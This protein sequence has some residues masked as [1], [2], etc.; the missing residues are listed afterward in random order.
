MPKNIQIIWEPSLMQKAFF[1][2]L[3]ILIEFMEEGTVSLQV[4][5]SNVCSKFPDSI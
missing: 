2:W 4:L 3:V 1:G 5:T